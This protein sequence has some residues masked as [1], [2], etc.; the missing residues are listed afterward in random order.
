MKKPKSIDDYPVPYI[1]TGFLALSMFAGI[2]LGGFFIILSGFF[3]G[4]IS[5]F[6]IRRGFTEVKNGS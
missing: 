3:L 1:L 2:F 6:I 5:S 4:L